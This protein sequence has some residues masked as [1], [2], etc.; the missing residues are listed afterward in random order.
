MQRTVGIAVGA[1][2]RCS[3]P[4]DAGFYHPRRRWVDCAEAPDD[5]FA[6]INT[7]ESP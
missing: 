2:I 5:M 7:R 4:P 3:P 6:Y 1:A